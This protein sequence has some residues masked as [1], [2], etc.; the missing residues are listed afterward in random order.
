MSPREATVTGRLTWSTVFAYGAPGI[1]AGYMGLML[2]L[3]VMKF[4]T[5]VLLIAPAVMGLIFSVSRIWDAISDPLAGYLSDRTRTSWGRRRIWLAASI[6][7]TG[8]TFYMVFAPPAELSGAALEGWMAL[9]I[10][11]FYSALTILLVPHLA[12]GAELSSDYHERS[13]LFGMRHAF[14]TSGSI[15]ALVTFYFLI[16]AEQEGAAQVRALAEQLGLGAAIVMMLL[17]LFAVVRLRE[18]P[19]YQGRVSGRPFQA[20]AD[21]WRNPHARLLIVVTFVENI[22]SAAIGV[23]TLYVA[24]YVIGEPQWAPFVILCYM[25]PSTLSVPLWLPLSRRF[26]KIRLWLFSMLLTGFAFGSVFLLLF[27]DSLELKLALI[28][29]AAVLAGLAAGCG[30]TVAP[31]IQGDVIDYDELVTGE[32]KEGSYFAAWNFV[33]KSAAGVMLLLTGFALDLSGFVPNQPQTFTVQATIMTLYALFPLVCYAIGAWL[34]RHFRLDE[35][36][37]AEIRAALDARAAG[38][39][40]TPAVPTAIEVPFS[41]R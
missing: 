36:A 41:D 15:L 40:A 20:F 13:R 3:Y 31:S 2:S 7:P 10:I 16:R 23:L 18:R 24:Q 32:R 38:A 4:A 17:I 19:D 34:F 33:F 21:V 6:L 29:G 12:L 1:G 8:F 9:S 26:G 35:A 14:F 28:M 22:G 39:S 5:D 27:I 25:V 30:G 11:G 37:H